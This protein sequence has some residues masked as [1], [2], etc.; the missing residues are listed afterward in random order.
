MKY[1]LILPFALLTG[2]SNF[3]L[4]GMVYCPA[5]HD[6]EFRQFGQAPAPTPSASAAK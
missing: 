1:L 3:Q 4:G 5:K 2:C 6:C